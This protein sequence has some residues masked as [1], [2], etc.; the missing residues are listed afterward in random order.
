[1]IAKTLGPRLSATALAAVVLVSGCKVG[2]NYQRP[3]V[4][5]PDQYRGNAPDLQTP[6]NTSPFAEMT[7][8]TVFQD[9]V[10]KSLIQE[11]LANN[12][13]IRIAATR[14]LQANDQVGIVRANQLPNLSGAFGINYQRNALALGGPTVDTAALSLNYIVDFW[15]QYRRATEAARAN[16]LASQYAQSV[17]QTTLIASVASAYY[18][19]RQYDE[20]LVISQKT[21]E[22]D[23]EIVRINNIKF[24]GGESAITD[25]YQADLL[26]EQAEAQVIASQQA[27]EQTE[28][29][30]SILLGRNPGSVARGIQLVDQ[31]HLAEI[32]TGLPSALLQR[33]PDVRQTEVL[34]IA[35][36]AN[37]GVAKAAFFPQIPLTALFGAS[38]TALTSF[39]QGPATIWSL[40]GQA[41]QPI[42]NGGAI[43]SAYKLAWAQRDQAELTYKQTVQNAFGEVANSLVGY[44]Q[45]RLY[46][47]KIEEQTKTYQDAANLANVRFNGGYA[48]FREV[49]VTEQQYFTSQIALTQ[50]WDNELANYVGLY[51]ALGGGWQ[52]Q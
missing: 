41:I 51:Q 8:Q 44:N 9:E 39:L 45:S 17:V 43:R 50:A 1:M 37:V 24:K 33:R 48:S 22:A 16:L 19:L 3:T 5:T 20:Q 2:P 46:R 40:G 4:S 11:A 35:A 10:L 32:P 6:A 15:G 47:M 26:M 18:Q 13:D 30:I 52:P 29:Q 21:V 31:P 42:Y 38:S 23:K 34:L 25:V 49:L 28:N 7:W 36:N 12:Y 27:V 14:V